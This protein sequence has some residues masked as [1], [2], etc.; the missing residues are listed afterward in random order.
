MKKEKDTIV[1]LKKDDAAL[2]IRA[3][4]ELE[5]LIPKG[6]DNEIVSD[7][8][9]TVAMLGVLLNAGDEELSELILKKTKTIMKA[10]KTPKKKKEIKKNGRNEKTV[11]R[12]LRK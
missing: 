12:K 9:F 11:S 8:V 4:G 5:V 3:N 1:K 10:Q 7:G 6:N 2:V